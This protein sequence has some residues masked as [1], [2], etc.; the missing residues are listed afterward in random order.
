[1]KHHNSHFIAYSV[2]I[3]ATLLLMLGAF[4]VGLVL[5]PTI[6]QEAEAAALS[7]EQPAAQLPAQRQQVAAASDVILAYEE[8]MTAI[9]E[10]TAPSVVYI[11]V[12][13]T[14]EQ[15][16]TEEFEF[17]SPFDFMPGPQQQFPHRGQGSGFVWDKDGH[18]LT[19]YHVVADATSVEV[20]F[21]NE[22]RVE[23]EVLGVD[24]DADLAILQVDMP[25][26]ELTPIVLGN[27]DDLRVGQLTIAIGNPF[28]QEFTMT[29][30]I[31]SAVGRVVQS[32]NSPFSIP[33]VI[34]TDAAINPGNSG[35]P[36]LNRKGEVIGINTQIIS[37]S[38]SNAGIGFAVPIDIARQIVPTLITGED[39]QYA[40]LGISGTTLSPEVAEF[41]KLP[42]D[43]PGAIILNVAQDGPADEA[44]LQGSD[45]TLT[46]NGQE[47]QLGGDVIT[48][49]NDQP[50]HD[51]NDL[52]T[53]LVNETEPDETVTLTVIRGDD[54]ETEEV[55]VTLGVRPRAD[56]MSSTEE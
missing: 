20:I 23:A 41:M 32:G 42:A 19:N 29:T 49:I 25:A 51:M 9:Y 8:A 18:I 10:K 38:G 21:A 4:G 56:E 44:G 12:I 40:W 35:G 30:G 1:M 7:A 2:T 37:R 33:K 28:G 52:I 24:P 39:Y 22:K 6:N 13:K 53:Y 5:A 17:N 27:S 48:A 26:S 3:T 16:A 11:N 36:L 45:K 31:V 15:P 55:A 43:T 47:F 54:G 50:I 34:Q 14:V 46:E